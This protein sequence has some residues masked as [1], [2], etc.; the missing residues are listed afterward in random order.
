MDRYREFRNDVLAGII[1][2]TFPSES[3]RILEVGCG[4]GLS[5]DHLSR[6]PLRHRL[7]GMDASETMLLQA[8]EKAA[9]RENPPKLL[10]AD[11][12][13]LPYPDGWFDVV[14]ATRFIH[15]FEHET[16]RRLWKEMNRVTRPGGIVIVEFYARPYHWLRYHLG[17]HKGKSKQAYFLHFPSREQVRDIVDDGFVI[18]PLRLAGAKLA[19]RVL[20]DSQ[21]RT[22][23]RAAGRLLGG[24]LLDEY[25]LAARKP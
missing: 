20:S 14:F 22:V 25:F 6:D 3:L 9:G 4:T 13:Q 8:A 19:A 7:F 2:E 1:R 17:A 16:K 24:A 11:A 5:L 21:L 10:L 15:Q 18:H 23:T 12:S